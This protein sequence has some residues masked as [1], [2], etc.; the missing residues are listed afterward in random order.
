MRKPSAMFVR[1]PLSAESELAKPLGAE[2]DSRF[3]PGQQSILV[4]CNCV[5]TS[6][7]RLASLPNPPGA[8]PA[9]PYLT[10]ETSTDYSISKTSQLR[11]CG[12][13]PSCPCPSVTTSPSLSEERSRNWFS[14][15]VNVHVSS[16]S[17]Y[18]RPLRGVCLLG[19]VQ[20]APSRRCGCAGR[21]AATAYPW[22]APGSPPT[23]VS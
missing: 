5:G 1:Q 2:R 18:I 22:L 7:D 16:G 13:C 23:L 21:L 6:P 12:A 20:Y 10:R 8:A 11:A 9:K 3:S 14:I 19:C 4:M 17:G 15:S